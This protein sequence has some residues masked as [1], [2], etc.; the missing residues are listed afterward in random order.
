MDIE[1]F[2]KTLLSAESLGLTEP[3]WCR[4]MEMLVDNGYISGVSVSNAMDCPHPREALGRSEIT[5][6]GLEY[7]E[8]N[9]MMK[10]SADIAK[11][12]QRYCTG[13]LII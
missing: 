5:L 2:D 3:K 10:K 1:E 13:N 9:S 4:I 11:R 6:K 8:E 12:N 7:L